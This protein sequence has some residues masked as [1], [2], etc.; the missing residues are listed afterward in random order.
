MLQ[1]SPPSCIE[2]CLHLLLFYKVRISE[3]RS[4]PMNDIPSYGPM[5]IRGKEKFVEAF[6][7]RE[8]RAAVLEELK[9]EGHQDTVEIAKTGTPRTGAPEEP[10]SIQAVAPQPPADKKE[11]TVL[12]YIDGHNDLEPYATYSMLDL[13]SVGSN[14]DVTVLAELGRISQDKLKEISEAAGNPYEPTNIDGDWSG[15]KRYVVMK[16][17]PANPQA[18]RQI[19]SPVVEDLG[20]KDMSDPATLRDFLAWGMK[21]YP[22]NH[23]LVV[24]M[25][26]GGGW[27]GAFTDDATASGSHIMTTPQIA[28]AFKEAEKETGVKPDVIDMVACL[29]GSG[30]VGYELKD[31]AQF[32][33]GS[34][35]IATTDAFLYSPVLEHLQK[36]V[37]GEGS[38]APKDLAHFLVDHYVDKP[39]AYVTKSSMDLSKME[40]MKDSI[41]NFAAVLEASTT[42][43]EA[44]REAINKAQ[45]FSR[46][47]YIEYY[48][49]YKDLYS[50]AEEI[51]KSPQ[52]TDPKVKSAASAVMASVKDAVINKI[53]SPYRR[54][55][56]TE[57]GTSPDGR[58]KVTMMKISEGDYD[59]EGISLYAPTR[60]AYTEHP[61]LM[62]K[63]GE[64]QLS[65]DTGWKDFLI[66]NNEQA[67]S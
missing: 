43:P 48:S 31:Q 61:G 47:F 59:A 15:V 36:T 6:E 4:A 55:E 45:S 24:L 11:W 30:E 21:K 63:Y 46:N 37:A 34:E 60:K 16:D 40:G 10:A 19:N 12:C 33:S 66:G 51:A 49:H 50:V 23:Y 27:M 57:T 64:L 14:K 20:E 13:E 42:P 18:V 52:V 3:E 67:E 28:Q 65:K 38:I 7:A 1:N 22:A 58:E 32:L 29:M 26:H 17:D 56:V 25:D 39:N 35:E 8:K 53:T 54:D 44:L 62:K 5:Q 9:K 2:S 41:K